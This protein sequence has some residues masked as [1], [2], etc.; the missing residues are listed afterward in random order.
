MEWAVNGQRLPRVATSLLIAVGILAFVFS[1]AVFVIPPPSRLVSVL[2]ANY[3][4]LLAV[5]GVA[6]GIAHLLAG[7]WTR[8]RRPLFR[9]V[10]VTLG[11]MVLLQVS[12][13][14]DILVV[15]LLALSRDEFDD[16][17]W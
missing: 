4:I 17:D 9:I 11:G 6:G 8:K 5:L 14:V 1:I 10:A 3:K 16:S 7:I 12:V 13:P 15:I 2:P